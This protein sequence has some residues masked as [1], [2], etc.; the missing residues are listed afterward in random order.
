[1]QKFRAKGLD[2]FRNLCPAEYIYDMP[3]WEAAADAVICRSGAMTVSELALMGKACIFIPSP[4]V[5][6]NHQF[7]NAEGLAKADAAMLIEEKDLTP[8]ALELAASDILFTDKGKL[9]SENIRR[10]AQPSAKELIYRE[11]RRLSNRNL[12]TLVAEEEVN[13]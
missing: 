13:E 5:T 8:K 9:F 6:A 3:K 7:K 2:S 11:L 10:F 4:N 1:M 12:L